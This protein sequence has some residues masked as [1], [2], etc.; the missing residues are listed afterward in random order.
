[1][2]RV[3]AVLMVMWAGPA[4]AGTYWVSP[5]GTQTTWASCQSATAPALTPTTNYCTLATANARAVAGDTVYLRGGDYTYAGGTSNSAI[6]PAASGTLGSRITFAAYAG[7]MPVLLGTWVA[8]PYMAGVYLATDY[9]VID[10][11]TIK[12]RQSS[13]AIING[14]HN[15]VKNCISYAT[16]TY[17]DGWPG[18]VIP[19]FLDTGASHNWLHHNTIYGY[20][21]YDAE[22]TDGIRVGHS[23]DTSPHHNT[24]SDNHVYHMGHAIAEDY[25]LYNVWLRN[26][27]HNEGWKPNEGPFKV[28]YGTATGGSSGVLRDTATNFVTAGA[29]VGMRVFTAGPSTSGGSAIGVISSITTTTNTNDTVNFSML[30]FWNPEFIAGTKYAIAPSTAAN[31]PDPPGVLPGDGKY[32]HRIMLISN[33]S[34]TDTAK[35]VLVEG[36]R[37]GHGAINY[38]NRGAEGISLGS[39][40]NI[41]R[42][43][44]IFGQDASGIG[45]K[46]YSGALHYGDN[47]R[48]YNNTF[49]KNGQA[50]TSSEA[51]FFCTAVSDLYAYPNTYRNNLL[52]QNGTS[53]C[54]AIGDWGSSVTGTFS[55][56]GCAVTDGAKGCTAVAD[57]KFV[58]PTMTDPM[59]ATLPNLALQADSPAINQGG[60]LTIASSGKTNSTSLGVVDALPFQD[61][62][63]GSSLAQGVV[64]FPDWIA[65]GTVSNVAQVASI[66]YGT[67]TITLSSSLTWSNGASVWLYKRGDGTSV[68]TGTAPDQGAYEYG[69]GAGAP[70]AP[71]NVRIR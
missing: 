4:F 63:L 12:N 67:N 64:L 22:G 60:A 30:A 38:A 33:D 68:L 47:N 31:V 55:N 48:V 56:N 50:Q 66:D 58:A 23:G 10:G 35:Y 54:D 8:T 59:S 36:N 51:G 27:F 49:Y 39:P 43:N 3:L 20:G 26:N 62:S 44:A 2:R 71:T 52:V 11:L 42:Y 28:I 57:P 13:I 14:H 45:I 18:A 65:I 32:S 6:N 25:G 16:S 15:E 9:I 17:P 46:S 61:G 7:E 70:S 40:G 34:G 29:S 19:V 41:I 1:M 24:L 37:L 5:T 53:E 21:A 69:A